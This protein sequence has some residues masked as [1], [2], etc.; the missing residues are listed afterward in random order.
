MN[1]ANSVG[2]G[3][4]PN[5]FSWA[6]YALG[7]SSLVHMFDDADLHWHDLELLADF[8]ANAVFTATAGA[9]QLVGAAEVLRLPRRLVGATTSSSVSSTDSATFSASLNKAIL[10][11]RGIG[12]LL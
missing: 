3:L 7:P 12:C 2:A 11:G 8:L 10:P 4:P 9:G 1:D 5:A 6:L